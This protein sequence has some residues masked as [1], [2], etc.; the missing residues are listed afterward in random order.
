MPKQDQVLKNLHKLEHQIQS[1]DEKVNSL[2]AKIEYFKAFKKETETKIKEFED[3][4][5]FANAER[6]LF[7]RNFKKKKL[8]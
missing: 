7:K 4:L 3:R 5:N 1:E 8:F 6:K 2:Q